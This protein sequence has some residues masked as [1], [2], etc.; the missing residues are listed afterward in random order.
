MAKDINN[1]WINEHLRFVLANI[2]NKSELDITKEYLRSLKE[3]DLSDQGINDITG[4][5]FATNL[6]NLNLNRNKII[7]ITPLRKLKKLVTLELSENSIENI[8]FLNELTKLKSIGLDSNNISFVPNLSDLKKLALINISNNKIKDLSFINTIP[9]EHIKVIASE[10]SVLLNP[11]SIDYGDDYTFNPYVT[12]DENNQVYYSNIQVT[13][14]YNKVETDERPS[15]LYSI[16]KMLI[17]NIYSDCIIKAEFY[18][19]VPFL[20]SGILSGILI[21]P[22][23]V[24]LSNLS[25]GLNKLR[26]DKLPC[27]ISGKLSVNL[28]IDADKESY[29]YHLLKN[30]VITIIDSKGNKLSSLTN[31]NGEYGFNDLENGRYTILFPFIMDYEYITPSLYMCNVKEGDSIIVDSIL[32]NK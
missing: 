22:I 5:Q 19:E 28:D 14:K 21:Q 10:Q 3:I 4:I 8:S 17:K 7:D 6:I 23:M 29:R 20:K 1:N 15:L 25:F 11:I 30:K 9:S 12:W 32:T 31:A 26:K 2:S 24:K 16:S 27:K 13:G 18:H